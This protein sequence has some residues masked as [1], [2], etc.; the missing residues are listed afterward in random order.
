MLNRQAIGHFNILINRNFKTFLFKCKKIIIYTLSFIQ[1]NKG[2]S[3]KIRVY[4][5]KG[6]FGEGKLIK[7]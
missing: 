3:Y 2:N 1:E 5:S 4:T 6:I 7:S